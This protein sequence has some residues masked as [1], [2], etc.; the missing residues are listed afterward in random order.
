MTFVAFLLYICW[1]HKIFFFDEVQELILYD[2]TAGTDYTRSSNKVKDVVCV[3][4]DDSLKRA[5]ILLALQRILASEPAVV[6]IDIKFEKPEYTRTDTLLENLIRK[7]KSRIVL[8][9]SGDEKGQD[10]YSY[11]VKSYED[12]PYL[13]YAHRAVN[14]KDMV[15][16]LELEDKKRTSFILLLSKLYKGK[17]LNDA[18]NHRL[19]INY[20]HSH[21][22]IQSGRLSH[23][24]IRNILK[25]KIVI[26]G[27]K[28]QRQDL[29]YTPRGI[30]D[31]YM[32][33]FHALKSLLEYDFN[34]C[35][36]YCWPVIFIFVS[37][38]VLLSAKYFSKKHLLTGS[39]ID[40]IM[41]VVMVC[42]YATYKMSFYIVD[43]TTAALW[44]AIPMIAFL[45]LSLYSFIVILWG[46]S[47]KV[48][49]KLAAKC[50][51]GEKRFFSPVLTLFAGGFHWMFNKARKS[52]LLYEK[53]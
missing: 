39:L 13:G 3:A 40:F 20:K 49:A 18:D 8:S 19:I 35:Y 2:I 6:G 51:S 9:Y 42:L 36:R 1:G 27:I 45:T 53:K 23:Q 17:E 22:P 25:G 7:N 5:D 46:K 29:H 50:S 14:I 12:Y 15:R 26:L 24:A 4:V 28:N 30:E 41:F 37:V 33:Q 34:F 44:I 47:E 43:Y 21:T 32:I 16:I 31:G 52:F 10:S 38:S 11:F 48:N